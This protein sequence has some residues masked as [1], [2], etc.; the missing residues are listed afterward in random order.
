MS[1]SYFVRIRGRVTGPHTEEKL[2]VLAQRGQF[3]RVHEISSDGMAWESATD[4][5]ELF[6]RPSE[7]EPEPVIVTPAPPVVAAKESP[8]S[9]S[10]RREPAAPPSNEAT[11]YYGAQGVERGPVEWLD[12]KRMAALGQ[13][14]PGDL[15][16]TEGMDS[17][18]PAE[19]VPGLEHVGRPSPNRRAA[20]DA[21][22][23]VPVEVSR[24][25]GA[26]SIWILLVAGAL[27]LGGAVWI[28][29]GVRP[30]VH[31]ADKPSTMLG[32]AIIGI[33]LVFVLRGV[34]LIVLQRRIA[35]FAYQRTNQQLV[36]L[37]SGYRLVWAYDGIVLL[38][39]IIGAL[40]WAAVLPIPGMP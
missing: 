23:S 20:P 30:V 21:D 24:A 31:S 14:Q 26:S 1:N 36:R 34:C 40:V 10:A 38:A 32:I 27:F 13:L 2:R 18:V 8:R 15:V 33:G 19:Q 12:L 28:A 35:A 22:E 39:I 25:A 4:H 9:G 16:W 17:W 6:D 3:S 11:W 37:L 7:P 5:P 29:A